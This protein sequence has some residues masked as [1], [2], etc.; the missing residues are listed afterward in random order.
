[1]GHTTYLYILRNPIFTCVSNLKDTTGQFSIAWFN[2][3]FDK[4]SSEISQGRMLRE[5]FSFTREQY[6]NLNTL[7]HFN[8]KANSLAYCAQNIERTFLL[9]PP[10]KKK[11]FI[12]ACNAVW[13]K[14]KALRCMIKSSN[15]LGSKSR[16]M[17]ST[18]HRRSGGRITDVKSCCLGTHSLC[19]SICQLTF[20][21]FKPL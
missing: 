5:I 3:P 10:P 8:R 18:C 13:E 19:Q 12:T 4:N 16:K 15:L 1:M 17:F 7:Y 2:L 20:Y 6:D 9:E 11:W 14:P 21:L